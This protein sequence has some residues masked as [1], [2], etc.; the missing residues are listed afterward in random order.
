MRSQKSGSAGHHRPLAH[1]WLA[2]L[3]GTAASA[4]TAS[5][6]AAGLPTL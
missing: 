6:V 3:G 5:G 2:F 4:G 1:E